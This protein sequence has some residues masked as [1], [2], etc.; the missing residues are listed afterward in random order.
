[1]NDQKLITIEPHNAENFKV[2]Y[3]V[4]TQCLRPQRRHPHFE[5]TLEGCRLNQVSPQTGRVVSDGR[6]PSPV[7]AKA[8]SKLILTVKI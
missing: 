1:M 8:K 2:A 7:V 3:P 6:L 5:Q 4:D